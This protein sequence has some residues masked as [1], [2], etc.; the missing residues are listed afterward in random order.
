MPSRG[1]GQAASANPPDKFSLLLAC[2][3]AYLANL[4]LQLVLV[5]LHTVLVGERERISG[6]A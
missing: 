4:T 5:Q 6:K 2:P 1:S 3:R